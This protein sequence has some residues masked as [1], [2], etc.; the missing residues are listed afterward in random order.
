MKASDS[1]NEEQR[2]LTV[3]DM[4]PD[5]QPRERALK[6]GCG[7]LPTA[8]LWALI[9]RTGLPGKPITDMCRD[10]MHSCDGKLFRLERMERA[11]FM[12]VKG[13]G[14]TK[15]LQIEAV[16]ELIRRY[17]KETVGSAVRITRSEDIYN[18]MR[19]E[20]GNLPHEEIWTLFLNRKNEILSKMQITRGS[21]TASVF[22]LKRILKEALMR[23]A[24]G[25]VMCHNH[26][27]GN[28]LSSIQDDDITRKMQQG[29]R[30]MDLRFLDHV[31]VTSSGFY[32]YAD[33]G[34]L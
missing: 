23:D 32:S 11:R 21:S 29:C 19:H 8:D 13:I 4:D 28:L 15:A 5:D 9:L 7:V 34:K 12:Q 33:N 24:D 25:V 27:S 16:M 20:I 17:C 22:D 14:T 6:H 10:L 2:I 31:I 1:Y 3:K 30:A 26:P 18:V